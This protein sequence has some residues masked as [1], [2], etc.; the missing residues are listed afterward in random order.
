MYLPIVAR[1]TLRTEFVRRMST[2]GA[3]SARV[4]ASTSTS[5]TSSTPSPA[6]AIAQRHITQGISRMTDLVVTRA[7]GAW[8][9]TDKNEKY[10]DFTSGIG[11]T[12]TGHC[13][14]KIVAAIRDQAGKLIHGQVNIVLHEPMIKLIERLLTIVPKGLDSFFFWNSGAEAVEASIKLARHYTGKP[15]I[16]VFQGGYHGRT[17]GTMSLTT[18]K[19]IYRARYGPLMPGVFVAPFPYHR[20]L[21]TGLLGLLV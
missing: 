4:A 17:I 3:D 13:H 12:N 15:N 11:V 18:S 19:Y 8:L 14:P 21:P 2:A 6:V 9:Y 7:E 1:R 16:I 5:S 10:L 20:Q